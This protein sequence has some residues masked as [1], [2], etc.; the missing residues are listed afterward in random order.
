MFSDT[1]LEIGKTLSKG[2]RDEKSLNS[3]KVSSLIDSQWNFHYLCLVPMNIEQFRFLFYFFTFPFPYSSFHC[4]FS[5]FV[6]RFSF[7]TIFSVP[8]LRRGWVRII[9]SRFKKNQSYSRPYFLWF[10]EW[11]FQGKKRTNIYVSRYVF[12]SV[13]SKEI[14]WSHWIHDECRLNL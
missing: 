4:S 12:P 8:Y 3:E 6:I 9:L 14:W 13:L 7:F 1:T 5:F 11:D 2:E 10:G